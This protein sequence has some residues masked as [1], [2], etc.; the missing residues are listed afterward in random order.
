M[1]LPLGLWGRISCQVCG[2]LAGEY[3]REEKTARYV[4]GE[5]REIFEGPIGW[6]SGR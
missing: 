3:Y 6:Y 2:I 1:E 4:I 5:E